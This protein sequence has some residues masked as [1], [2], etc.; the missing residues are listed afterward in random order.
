M[1][2]HLGNFQMTIKTSDGSIGNSK[3]ST[4]SENS[5]GSNKQSDFQPQ[6]SGIEQQ[7]LNRVVELMAD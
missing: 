1:S 2:Q 4:T 6:Q 3:K 7:K 5:S